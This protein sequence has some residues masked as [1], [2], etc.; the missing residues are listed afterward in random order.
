MNVSAMASN[1]QQLS[2]MA[3]DCPLRTTLENLGTSLKTLRSIL[4]TLE[5][6]LESLRTT[7]EHN[8]EEQTVTETTFALFRLQELY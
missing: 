6:T 5:A 2:T 8:A 4:E 1:G 7:L 3:S